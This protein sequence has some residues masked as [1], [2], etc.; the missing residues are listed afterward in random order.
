MESENEISD[1]DLATDQEILVE[2]TITL[3][4]TNIHCIVL[5]LSRSY[6]MVAFFGLSHL[7]AY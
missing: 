6:M 7:D 4:E 2:E 3:P 1:S 5:L